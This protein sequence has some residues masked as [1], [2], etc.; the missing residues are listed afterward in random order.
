MIRKLLGTG[1]FLL[2]LAAFPPRL[3]AQ[4]PVPT[5][6]TAATATPGETPSPTATELVNAPTLDDL[7]AAQKE[8]GDLEVKRDETFIQ[9]GVTLLKQVKALTQQTARMAKS[10]G[11]KRQARELLKGIDELEAVQESQVDQDLILLEKRSNLKQLN[12]DRLLVYNQSL[13]DKFQVEGNTRRVQEINEGEEF[14]NQMKILL[15]QQLELDKALLRSR[16]ACDFKTAGEIRKKQEDLKNQIE[17]LNKQ[18]KVRL[19]TLEEQGQP[20]KEDHLDQ[21][22]QENL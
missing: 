18:T 8:I 3:P 21:E 5:P 19:Q 10:S 15:V 20:R 17:E 14:L 16:M 11:D 9:Y 7:K 4:T 6:G 12:L 2:L 1:L 22:G 13:A